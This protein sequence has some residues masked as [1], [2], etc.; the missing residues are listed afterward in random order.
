V[1]NLGENMMQVFYFFDHPQIVV[2][3][4]QKKNMH[5]FVSAVMT[6]RPDSEYCFL[7][8]CSEIFDAW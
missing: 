7:E 8:L 3:P 4:P 6:S 5:F 1:V 2:Y